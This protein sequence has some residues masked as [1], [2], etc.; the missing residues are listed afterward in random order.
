MNSFGTI[1]RTSLDGSSRVIIIRNLGQ[2]TGMALDPDSLHLY[3]A[4]QK[5]GQIEHSSY[6]GKKYSSYYFILFTF[7][8]EIINLKLREVIVDGLM[9]CGR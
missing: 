4:D 7:G 1:E 2:V 3:W 8:C 6:D 9:F 5:L